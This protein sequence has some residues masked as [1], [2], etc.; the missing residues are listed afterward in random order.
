MEALSRGFGIH[1]TASGKGEPLVLIPGFLQN[2]SHWA[3]WGYVDRLTDRFRVIVL[4]PLGHGKSAKPY[5]AAAYRPLD[6]AG[7]VVAVLDNEGLEAAMSGATRMARLSPG[8]L[9]QPS[10]T[11]CAPS[12]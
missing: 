8:Q 1:Y 3:K 6:V 5:D 11:G 12:S 10:P 9:P 7:D 2:A 4:D